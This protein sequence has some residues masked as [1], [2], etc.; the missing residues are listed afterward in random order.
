ML[1][2]K[3]R[4]LCIILLITLTFSINITYAYPQKLPLLGIIITL[5][6]GHGGRDSGTLYN[7]IYEKD[8]NLNITKKLEKKLTSLGAIVYTIRDKDIDYSKDWDTNKKRGDLYRRILMIENNNSDLYLSIHN[9]WYKNTSYKGG[10]VYYNSINQN[11]KILAQSIQSEFKEKLKSKREIKTTNLYIY[12]NTRIPGVLIE[13]GYLSNKDDRYLLQTKKYQE[14]LANAI[15][16]GVI[17]YM[18][19][20]KQQKI[21]L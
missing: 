7:N 20:T 16:K 12:K 10:E 17:E 9:N 5:D 18:K 13:C 6:P 4:S 15:S 8:I 19:M 11:N 1:I 14:Q 3:Y 21:V 2:K